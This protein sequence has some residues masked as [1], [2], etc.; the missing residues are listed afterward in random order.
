[1]IAAI[2][3]RE[4]GWTWQEYQEQPVP[5]IATITAMLN[6]EAKEVERRNKKPAA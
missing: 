3:C 4:M 6:A 1:M 2:V 5:F